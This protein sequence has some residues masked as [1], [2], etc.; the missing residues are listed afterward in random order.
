LIRAAGA[1]L[2]LAGVAAAAPAGQEQPTFASGITLVKVD[3][4]V[5][6][7]DGKPVRGLTREDFR[8]FDEGRERPVAGFEAV[9]APPPAAEDELRVR[10]PRVTTNVGEQSRPPRAFFLFVY[11]G[12]RPSSYGA[13]RAVKVIRQFVDANAGLDA[14]VTLAATHRGETWTGTVRDLSAPAAFD[15]AIAA[16]IG[17][18]AATGANLDP[19]TYGAGIVPGAPGWAS[20]EMD[21]MADETRAKRLRELIDHFAAGRSG[22]TTM[23]LLGEGAIEDPMQRRT[24]DVVGP[25]AEHRVVVYGLDVRGLSA[26]SLGVDGATLNGDG[27]DGSRPRFA[28]D[29]SSSW[30]QELA[31]ATGGRNVRGTERLDVALASVVEESLSYY[32]LGFEPDAGAQPGRLRS[33]EVKLAQKG[34]DVRARPA[35]VVPRPGERAAAD[36][37]ARPPLPLRVAAFVQG[38]AGDGRSRVRL[39]LEVDPAALDPDAGG[40][41]TLESQIDAVPV[42]GGKAQRVENR[43]D[44]KLTPELRQSLADAWVPLARD[45]DL[46]PG[47][48][49]A[50]VVLKDTGTGRSGAVTHP[51]AVP[52]PDSLRITTPVATDLF[53]PDGGPREI[54]RARFDRSRQVE[55]AFEVLGAVRAESARPRLQARWTLR[56]AGGETLGAGALEGRGD[57]GT[58]FSFRLQ[59][60]RLADGAYVL[61]LAV[62]DLAGGATAEDEVPFEVA[63][64]AG[65][66]PG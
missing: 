37:P 63:S 21:R 39:V 4:V 52:S 33:I 62:H 49:E 13:F 25:A 60:G 2:V 29:G 14:D 22:R 58:R 35:Y 56:V 16:V 1:A 61:S 24:K 23:I 51:F 15:R 30:A 31:L 12:M 45:V 34:Y 28:M 66:P 9:V 48:Y 47:R 5:V 8:V 10:L 36:A 19:R 50:R 43:S 20:S 55:C 11:E 27:S 18:L 32:V 57:D 54:A 6:D 40:R 53:R 46:G 26:P 3:V 41:V 44:L 38:P 65:A 42:G 59:L 17:P 64:G 7:R